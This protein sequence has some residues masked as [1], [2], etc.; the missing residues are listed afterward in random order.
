MKGRN[1]TAVSLNAMSTK[2]IIFR[3][4]T[5]PAT[6]FPSITTAIAE[7]TSNAL[8]YALFKNLFMRHYPKNK[9]MTD[10]LLPYFNILSH[11]AKKSNIKIASKAILGKNFKKI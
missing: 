1:D 4:R 5:K 8:K 2:P 10:R 6:S 11:S 9:F 3:K 7:T